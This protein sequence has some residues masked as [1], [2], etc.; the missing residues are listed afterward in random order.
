MKKHKYR[1]YTGCIFWTNDIDLY[2]DTV[3]LDQSVFDIA[4]WKRC[5][6]LCRDQDL[7]RV[8]WSQRLQWF[9]PAG[10]ERMKEFSDVMF[11]GGIF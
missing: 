7:A 3:L 5:A 2:L 8:S 9:T 1:R 11:N 4:G 6:F 10:I